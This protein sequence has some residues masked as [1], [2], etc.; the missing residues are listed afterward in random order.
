MAGKTHTIILKAL[1]GEF[2]DPQAE[3]YL[4]AAI[5]NDLNTDNYTR[6]GGRWT[7][8]TRVTPKQIMDF[9]EENGYGFYDVISIDGQNWSTFYDSVIASIKTRN[10]KGAD[11]M[12]MEYKGVKYRYM[13]RTY[14]GEKIIKR[15]LAANG[16]MIVIVDRETEHI[17]YAVGKAYSPRTGHWGFGH[18]FNTYDDALEYFIGECKYPNFD[19]NDEKDLEFERMGRFNYNHVGMDYLKHNDYRLPGFDLYAHSDYESSIVRYDGAKSGRKGF[20]EYMTK[21]VV[22][23]PNKKR[24]LGKLKRRGRR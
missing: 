18:Y 14:D 10:T 9:I 22:D 3:M 13:D 17:P 5:E 23:N 6:N 7:I 19:P 11:K 21:Y 15:G 20:E 2:A 24:F 1:Y 8:R 12:P 16:M 4:E